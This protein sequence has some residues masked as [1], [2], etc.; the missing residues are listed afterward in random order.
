MKT[1]PIEVPRAANDTD[2][3]LVDRLERAVGRVLSTMPADEREQV[4]RGCERVLSEWTAF[5]SFIVIPVDRKAPVPH[6]VGI[7]IERATANAADDDELAAIVA[8]ELAARLDDGHPFGATAE[9]R[10]EQW[11]FRTSSTA[12]TATGTAVDVAEAL[13]D[14]GVERRP[15]YGGGDVVADLAAA[16]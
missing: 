9:E 2:P 16:L 3:G 5:S 12:T 7:E 15:R 1:I 14:L 11:G 10:A 6:A 4:R 8:V 13:A